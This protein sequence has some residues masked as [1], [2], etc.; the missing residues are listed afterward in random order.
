MPLLSKREERKVSINWVEVSAHAWSE[1]S[2]PSLL[3][4]FKFRILITRYVLWR[5]SHDNALPLFLQS[6]S[7]RR[8]VPHQYE[9]NRRHAALHRTSHHTSCATGVLQYCPWQLRVYVTPVWTKGGLFVLLVRTGCPAALSTA[10]SPLGQLPSPRR[11][12]FPSVH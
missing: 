2:V 1:C 5:T 6:S 4:N 8:V 11:M 9:G 10:Q 3:P 7:S 12:W